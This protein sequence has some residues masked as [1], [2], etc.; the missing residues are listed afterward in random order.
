MHMVLTRTLCYSTAAICV[1]CECETV[2][3][4]DAMIATLTHRVPNL[5]PG[6]SKDLTTRSQVA[7]L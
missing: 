5:R 7:L 3:M 1:V 6:I 4:L 2:V